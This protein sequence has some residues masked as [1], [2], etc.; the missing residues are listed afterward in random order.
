MHDATAKVSAGVLTG[1]ANQFGNFDECLRIKASE[2]NFRGKYC[3]AAMEM[4]VEG[5]NSY[6]KFLRDLVLTDVP[7]NGSF[8]DVNS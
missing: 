4:K 5:N 8:Q 2:E 6:L 1:N 3:L 7:F